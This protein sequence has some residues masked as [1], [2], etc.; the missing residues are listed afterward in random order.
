MRCRSCDYEL[1]E[2][3]NYC[4]E[5]GSEWERKQFDDVDWPLEI[6]I[7]PRLDLH[8]YVKSWTGLTSEQL[9]EFSDDYEFLLNVI[10]HEDGSVELAKNS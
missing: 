3:P 8:Y 4:P 10:V 7:G 2:E 6:Q 1:N 9:W 5:C